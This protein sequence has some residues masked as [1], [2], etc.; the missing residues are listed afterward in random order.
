MV[1]DVHGTTGSQKKVT[2]TTSSS[3]L[4]SAYIHSDFTAFLSYTHK[5]MFVCFAFTRACSD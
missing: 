4:Y 3:G 1:M 5:S 2:G